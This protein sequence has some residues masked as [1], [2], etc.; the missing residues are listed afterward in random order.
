VGKQI[1]KVAP[2]QDLYDHP[3]T[4]LR[5]DAV[6]ACDNQAGDDAAG[7]A[8]YRAGRR[9]PSRQRELAGGSANHPE[10]QPGLPAHQRGGCQMEWSSVVG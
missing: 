6:V 7:H 4:P 8:V 10:R 5:Y 2:D 3:V 9:K 1:I